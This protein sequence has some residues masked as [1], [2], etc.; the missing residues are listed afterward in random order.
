MRAGVT[1]SNAMAIGDGRVGGKEAEAV[2]DE[3]RDLG[4]EF[5]A[6]VRRIDRRRAVRDDLPRVA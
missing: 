1:A 6:G 3:S 2:G 4:V 5:F